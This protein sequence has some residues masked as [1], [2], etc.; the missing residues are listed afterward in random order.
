MLLIWALPVRAAVAFV[1][2]VIRCSNGLNGRRS[3]AAGKEREGIERL[4]CLFEIALVIV[5][6]DHVARLQGV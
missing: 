2:R 4:R 5:R 6:L 3:P 1:S